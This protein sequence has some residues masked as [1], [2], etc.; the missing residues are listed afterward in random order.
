LSFLTDWLLARLHKSSFR[1][2]ISSYL[3]FFSPETHN[4]RPLFPLKAIYPTFPALLFFLW[5]DF[6]NPMVY[7]FF[8]CERFSRITW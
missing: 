6:A 1:A 2:I 5:I 7:R 4:L 3:H 8:I